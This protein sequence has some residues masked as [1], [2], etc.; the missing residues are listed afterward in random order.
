MRLK[1]LAK[2]GHV[3]ARMGQGEEHGQHGGG[4]SGGS[5]GGHV[6]Q[7]SGTFRGLTCHLSVSRH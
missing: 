5:S 3:R 2:E 6:S 4:A 7:R 1:V